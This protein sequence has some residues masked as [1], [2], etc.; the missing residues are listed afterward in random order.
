[1]KQ[2]KELKN[3]VIDTDYSWYLHAK[4]QFEFYT[5]NDELKGIRIWVCLK[6]KIAVDGTRNARII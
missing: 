3:K 4:E 2:L 6:R 5:G 1:M